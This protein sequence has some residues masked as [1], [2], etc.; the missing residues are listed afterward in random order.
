LAHNGSN[1]RPFE[2]YRYEA[3][4]EL[5]ITKLSSYSP[6]K[7]GVR[8]R[9]AWLFGDLAVGLKRRPDGRETREKVED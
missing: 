7:P 3:A 9:P 8:G 5:R 4:D 2:I 6:Q 1:W